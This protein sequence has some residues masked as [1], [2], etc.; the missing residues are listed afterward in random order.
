MRPRL[1]L[2]QQAFA[3]RDRFP[4]GRSRFTA[5]ELCWEGRL[6]PAA[7]SRTYPI[8]VR[9]RL[10]RPPVVRVMST[11]RSRRGENLPHVYS[12]GSLCLN[13]ASDW[14]GT[15]LLADSTVQ[16]TAEWLLFYELWLPHGQWYGGGVWRP[17]RQ[18]QCGDASEDPAVSHG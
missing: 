5:G 12:D 2:G 15:M 8:R 14:N 18:P 16:W 7:T 4:A 9:Y 11:L 17:T 6:T 13:V 3:L 1:S 10:G